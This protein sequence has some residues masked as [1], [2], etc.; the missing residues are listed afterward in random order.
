V[1]NQL[2][3]QKSLDQIASPEQVHDYLR[4]TSPRMWMLIAAAVALAA[5]FVVYLLTARAEVISTVK[6][7]VDNYEVDG[8]QYRMASF[9]IKPDERNNYSAGMVVQINEVQGKISFFYE[10]DGVVHVSAD[11]DTEGSLPDGEYSAQVLVESRSPITVLF[12]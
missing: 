4:V 9:E 3:R 6:A 7:E 2:F 12:E 8:T 11:M 1:D 10:S 5:G